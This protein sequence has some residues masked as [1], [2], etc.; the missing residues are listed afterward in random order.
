MKSYFSFKNLYTFPLYWMSCPLIYFE[1]TICDSLL[2]ETNLMTRNSQNSVQFSKGKVFL[3]TIFYLWE[4]RV[5]FRFWFFMSLKIVSYIHIKTDKLL[6]RFKI[7]TD[8]T[9]YLICI[10]FELIEPKVPII[11]VIV[12]GIIF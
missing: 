8:F 2:V 4:N 5:F 1:I 3:F 11:F 7:I 6:K 9:P 12:M 10:A